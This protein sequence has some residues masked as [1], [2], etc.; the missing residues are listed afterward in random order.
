MY[1]LQ[2]D[3]CGVVLSLSVFVV[4]LCV[5][6]KYKRESE[7][8]PPYSLMTFQAFEQLSEHYIKAYAAIV[9]PLLVLTH[10]YIYYE[11]EKRPKF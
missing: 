11:G 7:N 10:F 8:F 9:C 6:L 5:S 2:D 4:L 1:S 3:D